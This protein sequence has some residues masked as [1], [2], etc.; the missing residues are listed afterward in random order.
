[1]KR[2]KRQVKASTEF[3]DYE[4]IVD[5]GGYIGG[6]EVY[7]VFAES[8]DDAESQALDL[9][10]DDLTIE[11]INEFDEGEWEV[12]VG[13]AGFIGV[14]EVYT[15]YADSEEEASEAA[16]EEAADDLE[17]TGVELVEE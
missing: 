5:F 17:V 4:V 12:E 2:M 14:S 11:D 7:E 3:N 15:V 10:K 1:M 6:D 13:F 16:I 9:A 8:R